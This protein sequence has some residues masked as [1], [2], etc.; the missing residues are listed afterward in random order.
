MVRCIALIGFL[1]LGSS[2]A[3]AHPG[4]G[5]V[6]SSSPLHYFLTPEHSIPLAFAV[7]ALL[8][9]V[10]TARRWMHRPSKPVRSEA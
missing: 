4:H 8:G 5:S 3:T 6:E 2:V 1:T 7:V 10:V 9:L